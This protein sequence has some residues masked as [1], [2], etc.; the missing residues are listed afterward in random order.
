MRDKSAA[1]APTPSPEAGMGTRTAS[2]EKH[3]AILLLYTF[4]AILATYPLVFNFTTHA[5]GDITDAPALTWNL[6]W[7]KFS[8]FDQFTNP[9]FTN[10]IF[11]PVGVD[12]VAYTLTL[13]N[14]FIAI[15]FVCVSNYVAANNL[16]VLLELTLAAYGMYLLAYDRLHRAHLDTRAAIFAGF[17]YGLGSYHLNYIALGQPNIAGN[18]WLAFYFF[19]LIRALESRHPARHGALAGIFFA[20]SAWTELTYAAF[21]GLLTLVYWLVRARQIQPRAFLSHAF[22][23]GAIALIAMMPILVDMAREYQRYGDYW[24]V[25][26]ARTQIFSADLFG[27]VLPSSLNPVFGFLTRNLAF[28]SINWTFAGFVPLALGVFSFA[29]FRAA[30]VWGYIALVFAILMLGPFLQAAGNITDLPLPFNLFSAIPLLKSNRY[31]FR[32][33]SIFMLALAL[34]ASYALAEILSRP[35]WKAATAAMLAFAFVEQLTVP[36]PLTDLRVP[37]IFK[38][39]RADAGD[40]AVLD[41]PLGWR[42]SARIQGAVDYRAHFWQSVHQKRLLDG[43]TSRN[44]R[45]KFQYFLEAPVINS[46]IALENGREV[47]Y[48]RR[49]QDRALARDVL[50]FFDIRYINA[51]RSKTDPRILDY[52]LE[53]FP[54][55]EIYRDEERTVYRVTP[56][57]REQGAVDHLAEIAS[58]YFDDGWGRAQI[59]DDGFGYRWATQSESRMWLPLSKSDYEIKF[60]MAG[61]RFSE[62]ISVYVNGWL[63]F[64]TETQ[65]G[66]LDYTIQVPASVLRDGLNEITFWKT[67]NAG[68][69]DERPFEEGSRLIGD[70]GV[71]SPVNISITAAGFDAGRFGEIFVAGRNV[72]DGRRGYTLVA[73]NA[74]TGAVERSDRFDTFADP[75]ESRRLAQFIESLPRGTIVAGAAVDDVSKELQPEAIDALRELGVESDLR[76]Q[77]RAAHTFIGVKGAQV[78][79]AVE[80]VGARLPANVSVGKNVS[81]DRV[82]FALGPIEWQIR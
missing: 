42:N 54:A 34:L 24:T 37:D 8:T 77:F 75:N 23:L 30:R 65:P 26:L 51:F 36:M 76:F 20:L 69:E 59:A 57:P 27:F 6:W 7:I 80:R 82:A 52:I 14:G 35:R 64:H 15:P 25:G 49:A 79:Q 29:R 41:L 74:K 67:E 46:I 11:Y 16:I 17:V 62:G 47:D 22:A 13:W 38:T 3:I 58:L 9:L 61:Q 55:T 2:F 5:P 45:F 78:G 66:W 70:T 18:H 19:F 43:N 68:G 21:L 56:Q 12:L 81:A 33:N 53:V 31:P 44:P 40:F 73:I 48:A 28:Q 10:Y 60:K 1:T 4:L 50:R 32:L 63:A 72:I 39:I 71:I